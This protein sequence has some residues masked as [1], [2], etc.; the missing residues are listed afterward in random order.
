MANPLKARTAPIPAVIREKKKT[1]EDEE[2]MA[3]EAMTMDICSKASAKS[4]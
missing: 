4:K 1:G 2:R 3:I